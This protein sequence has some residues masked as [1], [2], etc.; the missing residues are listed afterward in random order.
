MA[1]DSKLADY[2]RLLASWPG[3]IGSGERPQRLVEDSL[4]LLPFLESGSSLIDVGTGGGMPGIPLRI[5]QPDLRVTLLESDQTKASFLVFALAELGLDDVEVVCER[6]ETLA[7]GPRRESFEIACC[8][9]LAPPS[10][11]AE[12]CLPLVRIG[13]RALLMGSG[14]MLEET[15]SRLLGGA[16]AQLLDAPSAARGRGTVL[17]VRKLEPTPQ[18]FPRRAGLASRRPL[19]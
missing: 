15:T 5:A 2:C 4:V 3:L 7:R 6:A 10:G 19:G 18:R 14:Q 9:A 1:I 16:P 12:L 13:G 17:Q 11:A 8:R